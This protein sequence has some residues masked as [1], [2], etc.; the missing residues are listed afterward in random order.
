MYRG[1]ILICGNGKV[2]V[3]LQE[4]VGREGVTGQVGGCNEVNKERR[5]NGFKIQ[6]FMFYHERM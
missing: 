6:L 4:K 2:M 1:Y 5:E 3:R